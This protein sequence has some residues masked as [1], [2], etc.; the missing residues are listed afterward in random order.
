MRTLINT[1]VFPHKLGS[2]ISLCHVISIRVKATPEIQN[3]R[4]SLLCHDITVPLPMPSFHK[5]T[6]GY[7]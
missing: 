5:H 3:Y 2:D 4:I 7:N 6:H 1:C